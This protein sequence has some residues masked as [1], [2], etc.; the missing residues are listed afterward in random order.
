MGDRYWDDEKP[1]FLG[2]FFLP[3]FSTFVA[4]EH[5]GF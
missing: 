5:R 3:G 1:L 4:L 2:F